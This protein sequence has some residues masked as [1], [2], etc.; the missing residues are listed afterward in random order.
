MSY[1]QIHSVKSAFTTLEE[2][3]IFSCYSRLLN[4]RSKQHNTHPLSESFPPYNFSSA[5][6]LSLPALYPS[7]PPSYPLSPTFLLIQPLSPHPPTFHPSPSPPLPPTLP[8]RHLTA[9]AVSFLHLADS[10]LVS[11]LTS[12][13]KKNPAHSDNRG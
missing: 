7:F 13:M 10:S 8:S 2:R 6:Q 1:I 12:G 9:S 5:L 3:R 4:L 11:R